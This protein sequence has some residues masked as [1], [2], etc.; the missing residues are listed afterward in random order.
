MSVEDTEVEV[1]IVIDDIPGQQQQQQQQQR[2]KKWWWPKHQHTS[3]S[4][5]TNTA[6]ATAEEQGECNDSLHSPCSAAME[7]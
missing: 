3:I 4:R 5:L 2:Q 1:K 6:T 7:L